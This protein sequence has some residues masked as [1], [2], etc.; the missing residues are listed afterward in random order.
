MILPPLSISDNF[1]PPKTF[2]SDCLWQSVFIKAFRP[3]AVILRDYKML[4][5][6]FSFLKHFVTN[7][8]GSFALF[9]Q[10]EAKRKETHSSLFAV[11]GLIY[12]SG[13]L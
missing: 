3:F 8:P 6:V 9:E 4:P 10:S 7:F 2:Q 12:F 13:M 5:D 11:V 1:F